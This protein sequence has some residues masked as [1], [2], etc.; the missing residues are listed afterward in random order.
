[1]VRKY[2]HHMMKKLKIT[3]LFIVGGS[4][5][6]IWQILLFTGNVE[7][8]KSQPVRIIAHITAELATAILL[9]IAGILG[10]KKTV[11]INWS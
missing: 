4:I 10:L 5:V 9:I 7:E 2:K 1:M 3:S 8:L 11:L 6:F